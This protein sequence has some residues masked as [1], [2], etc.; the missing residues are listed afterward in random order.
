MQIRYLERCELYSETENKA[1]NGYRT[2]VHT[3]VRSFM[4]QAQEVMDEVSATVYGSKVTNMLRL[5]SVRN[6]LEKYLAAKNIDSSSD[7]ISNYT[8]VMSERKKRYKI[9]AVKKLF[10]DV[11]YLESVVEMSV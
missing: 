5:T 7:N 3:F 1:D 4:V 9:V 11:E 6:E 10:C 8:I 2:K